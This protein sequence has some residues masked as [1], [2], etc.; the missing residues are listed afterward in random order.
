MLDDIFTI[1]FMTGLFSAT[2]RLA[3]P[4][5]F[6]AM[7]EILAERSGVINLGIEGI[8]IMGAVTG[9]LTTLQTG[10][11]WAG[12]L[13]ASIIGLIFGLFMA[14]LAVYLGLSQHVA[15]L[16]IT[17]LSTGLAM[18]VYRL[19]VGAPTVPPIISPFAKLAVPGLSEIPL[20]GEVFFNQN[21]LVYISWAVILVLWIF[22]YKTK[23]GLGV[24]TV[25]ENPFAADT[26]G[27][28]VNLTRTVCLAVGGASMGVAGAFLTLAHNNM[29][30]IDIVGGRG[31]VAVAMVIFG[32]W[33]PLGATLGALM[34]GFLDAFQLR[35]Q[36]MGADIPFH[37]FLMVPYLATIIAL[38]IGSSSKAGAPAGLLKPYR[39][40]EKGS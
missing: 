35:L 20:L 37:L 13:V 19:V 10:S 25:G 26:V 6:A 28:N 5:I 21:A 9:F 23:W 31:W 7:G 39:R 16:G 4:I 22:L 24:R 11:L 14:F 36:V 29:F 40:E 34:F 1:T 38:I 27:I 2:V 18:Y 32:R 17:L 3:A 12:V 15:G 30:L 33:N 8:M